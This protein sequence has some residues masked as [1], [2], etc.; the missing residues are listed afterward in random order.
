MF[1]GGFGSDVLVCMYVNAVFDL[2]S[3]SFLSFLAGREG[4]SQGRRGSGDVDGPDRGAG[5]DS[6]K[7]GGR[8]SR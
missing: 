3:F 1:L 4:K 8:R 2:V 5:A 6:R 7:L